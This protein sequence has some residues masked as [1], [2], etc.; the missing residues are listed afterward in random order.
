VLFTD[1]TMAKQ[2]DF[3]T[4]TVDQLAALLKEQRMKL[5]QMHEDVLMNKLKNSSEIKQVRRQIAR[6]LTALQN[7]K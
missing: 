7:V 6:V 5:A 3:Q 4:M 1:N 2:T